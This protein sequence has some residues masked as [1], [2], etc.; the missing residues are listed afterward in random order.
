MSIFLLIFEWA[1]QQCS[2]T[3]LPVIVISTCVHV[4][5]TDHNTWHLNYG[6]LA[7]KYPWGYTDIFTVYVS[8]SCVDG[9]VHTYSAAE[10]SD[11]LM[12]ANAM[13]TYLG[14]VFWP[15]PTKLL[16]TCKVDVT[17]FPF[18]EQFCLLKFGS[19]TYDGFQVISASELRRPTI[20]NRRLSRRLS[21]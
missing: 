1:L 18:D 15:V 14:N 8:G 17:Y 10:Y 20:T 12:P 21:K 9:D 2:A 4:T 3:A 7:T 5:C 11:G 16:S 19:W 13:I 6:K